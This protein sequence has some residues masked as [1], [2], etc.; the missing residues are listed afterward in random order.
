MLHGCHEKAESFKLVQLYPVS[1][2]CQST[3]DQWA[4]HDDGTS[5]ESGDPV[6]EMRKTAAARD[7]YMGIRHSISLPGNYQL[8][9]CVDQSKTTFFPFV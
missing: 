1:G 4:G 9:D 5:D 7:D 6:G 2:G 3:S 8:E